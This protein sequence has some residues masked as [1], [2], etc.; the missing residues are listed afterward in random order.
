MSDSSDICIYQIDSKNIWLL[1]T[2]TFRTK[3]ELVFALTFENAFFFS[4]HFEAYG[5]SIG[6]SKKWY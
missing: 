3:L 5:K 2:V 4:F 1:F 6:S